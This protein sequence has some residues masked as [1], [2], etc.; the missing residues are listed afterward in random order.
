MGFVVGMRSVLVSIVVIFMGAILSRMA[1]ALALLVLLVMPAAAA[2]ELLLPPG[3][4]VEV[5]VTGDGFDTA[6]GRAAQGLPS[7]STIAVDGAGTLYMARTGRRYS[8]G[9]IDDLWPVF[10]FPPGGARVTKE[11]A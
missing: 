3:F 8:G 4:S 2:G 7:S 10:R 6:D 1:I 11:N 9:E 5:Y